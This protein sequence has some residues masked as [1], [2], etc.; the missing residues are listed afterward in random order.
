MGNWRS[1]LTLWTAIIAAGAAILSSALTIYLT[2]LFVDRERKREYELKWLEER[3]GPAIEFLGR[4]IA[5]VNNIPNTPSGRKRA[6]SKIRNIVTG[7]SKDTNAWYISI[8]LDPEDTGLRDGVFSVMRYARIKDSEKE[9][10]E[11]QARLLRHLEELAE[12]YR[13]ERQAIAKGTSLEVLIRKR[14][15][16]LDKTVQ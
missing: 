4:V 7:S 11:Y 3:F 13:T 16:N 12:E 9:F 6:A 10:S 14:K 5:A 1:N 15:T 8:L 2:H